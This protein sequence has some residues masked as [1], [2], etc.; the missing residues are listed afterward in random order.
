MQRGSRKPVYGLGRSVEAC[1]F[2]RDTP[3]SLSFRVRGAIAGVR[4]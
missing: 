4:I 3:G 2:P 1:R